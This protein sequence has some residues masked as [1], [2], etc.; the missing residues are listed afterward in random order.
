M[1]LRTHRLSVHTTH[2]AAIYRGHC[3]VVGI[4]TIS[5][6]TSPYAAD[7]HRLEA[8]LLAPIRVA[9]HAWATLYQQLAGPAVDLSPWPFRHFEM[10]TRTTSGCVFLLGPP[11]VLV[12]D[13]P[14]G[15]QAQ[16]PFRDCHPPSARHGSLIRGTAQ[17]RPGRQ[18]VWLYPSVRFQ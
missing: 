18:A 9:R 16:E 6:K 10:D 14:F 5:K 8:V 4:I 2:Y 1:L 11:L 3:C 12:P 17:L 13:F 15:I 7:P